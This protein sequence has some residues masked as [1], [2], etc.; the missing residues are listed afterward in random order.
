MITL[1]VDDLLI[2]SNCDALMAETKQHM[3]DR[4]E[5]KDLGKLRYI[6]GIEV[7]WNKDGSCALRQKQYII[8]TLEKFNI[9][10]CK[11]VTTPIAS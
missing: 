8:D 11:P 9:S 2:A 7:L 5:M 10:Q 6:L 3:N 4:F 1:Y